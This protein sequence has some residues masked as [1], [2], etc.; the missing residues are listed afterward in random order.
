MDRNLLLKGQGRQ[1][2]ILECLA[3][4]SS[5][6]VFTPPEIANQMLD[7]LPE[8]VW[9]NPDLKWLDPACKTGV[10]LREA[11]KRLMVGLKDAIPDEV[12]RRE[13]IFK[14]MLHGFAI[15][16]LTALVSRRTL[17][18]S[19]DAHGDHAIIHF[20]NPDG[21]I[22][23][24]RREHTWKVKGASHKCKQ[25]GAPESIEHKNH[26]WAGK[27]KP[28][29]CELC[30]EQ[31][32]VSENPEKC[33]GMENHAYR[34]IHLTEKE[35]QM[36][37]DVII[38]NPPYQIDAKDGNR[39]IPLY[40]LFFDTAKKLKPE[41]IAFLIPSRWLAGGLGLTKFR[42]EMLADTRIRTMVNFPNAEEVF[43]GVGKS[44]KGGV[45]YLIWQRDDS[46][47]CLVEIR[48]GNKVVESSLRNL[49]EFDVFVQDGRALPILKKVL[50]H[51][52]PS[53]TDILAADKEFGIS[54]NYSEYSMS[55]V[56]GSIP[57]YLRKDHQRLKAWIKRSTVSKSVHLINYW[58]VL[59]PEA[60][61]DGGQKL[62]DV[63]LGE[64]LIAAPPSACTQTYLFFF[65]VS[66][67]E[68]KSVNSYLR[69]RFFRFL[70]SLRK[71]T[72]HAT[73]S[74]YLW[75]PIQKWD[76][77]WTDEELYKKYRITKSEQ[78]YIE[79]CVEEVS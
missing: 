17:Y 29:Y 59:V 64:S 37:F 36:K 14:N 57:L 11:A 45:Q 78:K 74:T 60:G 8:E 35:K 70:V 62:P 54:S 7:L 13:H 65:V 52:E 76:K 15:T 1:P 67:D 10:F 19:K 48:R 26:T 22:L 32:D 68:A 30:G 33:K 31:E 16:E 41:Y 66:E 23:Y 6:E 38:G 44:I 18:Y 73:R 75:V 27:E 47:D 12:E 28:R 51:Q 25:C 61:S 46:G 9:S 24:E 72:Q 5:D 3:N 56:S 21:N 63:V 71:I 34:F 39:T 40:N 55:K 49:G 50:T 20:D 4:L 79:S 42:K 53:I 58:K 69:T 77:E 43:P 2:D